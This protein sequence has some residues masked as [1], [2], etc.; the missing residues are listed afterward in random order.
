M[1]LGTAIFQETISP[2]LKK[3]GTPWIKLEAGV[4]ISIYHRAGWRSDTQNLMGGHILGLKLI[5][6]GDL[7]LYIDGF[8]VQEVRLV[9]PLPH[10]VH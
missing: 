5:V 4:N 3:R 10:R 8:A 6:D 2:A 1:V 7:R 9:P